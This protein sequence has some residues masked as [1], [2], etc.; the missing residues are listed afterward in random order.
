MQ[1]KWLR[2]LLAAVLGLIVLLAVR[3]HSAGAPQNADAKQGRC[4]GSGDFSSFASNCSG[5]DDGVRA[6]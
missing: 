3:Q 6:F 1:N 4:L 2:I 5:R